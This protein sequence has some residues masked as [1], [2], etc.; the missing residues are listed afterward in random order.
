MIRFEWDDAKSR[1]NRRKHG[2]SFETARL[3]FD[4]PFA[5][6]RQ[7]RV[8]DGEFRWQAI[9]RVAQEL[10]LVVAHTVRETEDGGGVIRLIS[11]RKAL[12]GERK[13]Y[14][15]QTYG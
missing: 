2:L 9:G 12:K 10:V 6:M 13:S 8:V 11:A 15:E 1:T 4:D 7:D 3:V 14:E 5:L